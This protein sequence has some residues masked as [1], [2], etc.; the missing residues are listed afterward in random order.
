MALSGVLTRPVP[1]THTQVGDPQELNAITRA[2]C[3]SRREPLLIGSTKSN[4]GHPE[5]VSGLAAL[6]K[7]GG[8]VRASRWR[9][10]PTGPARFWA[11]RPRHQGASMR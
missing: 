1:P 6:A 8:P 9:E 4:M 2:L 11:P 7:V 5:P 3:D 10:V